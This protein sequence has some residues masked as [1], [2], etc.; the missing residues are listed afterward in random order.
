MDVRGALLATT[1]AGTLLVAA[2]GGGS[3]DVDGTASSGNTPNNANNSGSTAGNVSF[4]PPVPAPSNDTSIASGPSGSLCRAQTSV[5]GGNL[6]VADSGPIGVTLLSDG[7]VGRLPGITL[8]DG[9]LRQYEFRVM[10]DTVFGI[11]AG[12]VSNRQDKW[13]ETQPIPTGTPVG[14]STQVDLGPPRP[15]LAQSNPGFASTYPKDVPVQLWLIYPTGTLSTNDFRYHY[16]STA[17][18]HKDVPIG[19][20]WYWASVTYGPNYTATVTF[21]AGT[22]LARFTVGLTNVFGTGCPEN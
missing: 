5:V 21:F 1:V 15:E 20:D 19:S 9:T 10:Y 13:S 12:V 16:S 7:G 6:F 17:S 22:D 2:C 3:S 8:L 11:R 14:T 4:S 18:I